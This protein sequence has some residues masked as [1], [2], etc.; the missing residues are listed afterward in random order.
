MRKLTP[1][2]EEA[3][4]QG[5]RVHRLN[6]GQPDLKT[7][8]A[9]RKAVAENPE[10]VFAYTRSEGAFT[11][12][13][14]FRSYYR[15]HG[16][17][18]SNEEIVTTTGGSEAL[19]FTLLTLCD[20]GDEVLVPE[21]CYPSYLTFSSMTGVK[22]VPLT[23]RVEDGYSLPSREEIEARI[24]PRTRAILFTN[25]SNPTGK[26]FSVEEVERLASVCKEKDLFL[27]ADEVYR[28]FIFDGPGSIG[29]LD[30]K[31]ME[32]RVI[33][34]DSVSKRWSACG[35]RIG[36]LVS[37]NQDFLQTAVRL[38]RAR[39][40]APFLGQ[41]AI[42]AIPKIP[43]SY[44]EETIAEYRRRRDTV[45][46]ALDGV[47]G[48]LAPRPRGAF[49][50]MLRLPVDSSEDFARWLLTDFEY[51]G[52]T[53]MVSPGPGFYLTEGAGKDEVRL[54]FMVDCERLKRACDCLVRALKVY[55][56]RT[57]G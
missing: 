39:L 56:G 4:R 16:W 11:T 2:A 48:L 33:V 8:E 47:P 19:F 50:T 45:V 25:P 54:A 22:L 44:M 1:F 49:Y 57:V 15:S 14:A 26:V 20:V 32:Q 29:A 28:E 5:K 46:E 6:I 41:V 3:E 40:S 24:T 35:L 36:C 12:L 17:D 37:R 43:A 18:L 42:S 10:G 53:L 51:D 21:P 9:M 30:L 23:T 38:A 7:P 13:E 55:P 31:G 27:V 52:E 34:C